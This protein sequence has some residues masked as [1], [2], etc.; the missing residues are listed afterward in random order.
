VLKK[1]ND[2]EAAIVDMINK[3]SPF[4]VINE[5]TGFT[6]KVIKRIAVENNLF[7]RMIE[8]NQSFKRRRA[9]ITH[10]IQAA[11]RYRE[12]D[13]VF[14]D[15]IE[16]RIANGEHK[17]PLI[18]LVGKSQAYFDRFLKWKSQSL[19]EALR[20][21]GQ[22]VNAENRA[23]A[24]VLGANRTRGV[25]LKKITEDIEFLYKEMLFEGVHLA[26]IRRV[27]LP[28]GFGCEK[29]KQ[30]GEIWGKPD[31]CD[32]SGE[33]NPMYG[34]SAPNGSGIGT[35][36]WVNL[37]NKRH[38]FR[39]SLE[40]RIFLHLYDA[41]TVFSLSKHRIPYLLDGV[42]RTYCPDYVVGTIVYEIK[43]SKLL[44]T[45]ENKT[46][47]SAAKEYLAK[48][49]LEFQVVTEETFSLRKYEESDIM[50][51]IDNGILEIDEKNLTKLLKWI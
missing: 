17:V 12:T 32:Q 1:T 6:Y 39:S 46:K 41:G 19:V 47:F 33:N 30:M 14:G 8:N 22:R 49:C 4:K 38:F 31:R 2:E 29:V 9:G 36:G 42:K 45:D 43:P 21:N 3:G 11:E 37:G 44:S 15:E 18:A 27:M 34:K 7:E 26:E 10:K 40:M 13:K 51:M 24:S 28:L 20:A 16:R 48:R 23:K 5:F 25:P 35:K 50:N